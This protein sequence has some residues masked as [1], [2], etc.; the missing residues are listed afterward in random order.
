MTYMFVHSTCVGKKEKT[1]KNYCN[2]LS[3]KLL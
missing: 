3:K 1:R 2:K